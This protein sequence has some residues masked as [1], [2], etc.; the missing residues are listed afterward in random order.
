VGIAEQASAITGLSFVV[1][2]EDGT[3]TDLEIGLDGRFSQRVIDSLSERLSLTVTP[4][5]DPTTVIAPSSLPLVVG[6][7]YKL[8]Y[9]DFIEALDA[10][11]YVLVNGPGFNAGECW[12]FTPS[13]AGSSTLKVTVVDRAGATV[14]ERAIPVTVHEAPAGAGKRHLQIGDSITRAGNYVGAAVAA[15]GGAATVGTRTYNSGA[16]NVEGRGGWALA[17]YFTAIGSATGGDSPFL[18]PAGIAGAKYWGNTEFWRKVCYVAMA[19]LPTAGYDF[20]GFQYIA[21]GWKP[22]GNPY[23]Y[24]STGYPVAPIEGDVVIDPTKATTERFRQ[25]VGGAWAAMSPQPAVEISFPKYMIRYAAAYPNGGPTSIGIMLETN[26]FFNQLDDASFTLWKSRMDALI[27]SVRAWSATVP[28]IVALAPTGGPAANW[29]N[30]VQQ[31]FSF[32]RRIR[33]ASRR[34]LTA[35]DTAAQRTNRVHVVTFLGSVSPQNMSDHVHPTTPAGHDE[36]AQFLAGMLAKL[37]TE[38]A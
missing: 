36:M 21:R 19:D 3:R 8:Y 18:F 12:T 27:A 6:R 15:I 25:Y 37:I 34:I 4:A 1:V 13:A 16:L 7:T 32:D 9:A 26:D 38:G 14:S 28:F 24:D 23:L 2:D 22:T 20:D 17:N 11:A 10:S 5:A 31:K 33:E 29:A 35:Y 30:Q